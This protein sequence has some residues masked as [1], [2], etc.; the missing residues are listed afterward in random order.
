MGELV[1]VVIPVFNAQDYLK[2]C[3]DSILSQTYRNIEVIVVDNYSTDSSFSICEEYRKRDDRIVVLRETK[4]GC[5]AVRNAGMKHV[6]GK[7]LCFLDSD[8]WMDSEAIEKCVTE[9]EKN[10]TDLVMYSYVREYG[11]RSANRQL[12]D[13][14]IIIEKDE[15]RRTL[16]RRLIGLYGDE[17]KHPELADS[18]STAWA[19]LYRTDYAKTIEFVDNQYIGTNEDGLY[20]LDYFLLSERISYINQFYYHYRKPNNDRTATSNYNIDRI[21]RW[22]H[23]IGEIRKRT[24]LNDP[25]EAAALQNRICLSI[26]GQTM[27]IV[28]SKQSLRQKKKVISDLLSMELY[29]NAFQAL[30]I[31]YFPPHWKLFFYACKKKQCAAVLMMAESIFRLRQYIG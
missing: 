3:L 22:Q 14:D 5:S 8:D 26:I 23:M 31:E 2:Q 12:F 27:N 29:T 21:D 30:Q 10:N 20:N 1:S 24:D 16:R 15:I 11:N 7:Y 25:I 4:K 28:R 6:K 18:F 19:K 9:I 17:L 13:R